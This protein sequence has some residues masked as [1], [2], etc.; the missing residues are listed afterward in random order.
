M[1]KSV[2]NFRRSNNRIL[3]ENIKSYVLV[4]NLL[5][6]KHTSWRYIAICLLI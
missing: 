6:E 5:S 3:K 1:W 2:Y 4:H